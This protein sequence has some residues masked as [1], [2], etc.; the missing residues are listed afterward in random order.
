MLILFKPVRQ[1]ISYLLT[2]LNSI[3]ILRTS[4]IFLPQSFPHL[5]ALFVYLTVAVYLIISCW[6]SNTGLF[7]IQ[8]DFSSSLSVLGLLLHTSIGLILISFC[9]IGIGISRSYKE[10]LN[11]LALTTPSKRQIIVG[12]VLIFIGFACDGFWAFYTRNLSGQDLAT[13]FSYYRFDTFALANSFIPSLIL[14]MVITLCAAIGEET[15]MRGAIQPVFG[16]LPTAL[17]H[18]IFHGQFTDTPIFM[19]KVFLWSTIMGVVKHYTNTT[20]VIIAHAGLNLIAV[21]L[22]AAGF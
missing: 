2:A 10:V 14:A 12:I 11:R 19:F 17:L 20:T 22:F 13:Q 15:L 7:R 5:I 1:L 6:A 3:A 16:V 21:L 4:K 9:G 8:S 18:A